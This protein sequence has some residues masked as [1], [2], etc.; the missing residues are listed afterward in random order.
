MLKSNKITYKVS[1]TALYFCSVFVIIYFLSPRSFQAFK[2]EYI[3]F[4]FCIIFFIFYLKSNFLYSKPL[5]FA[6]NNSVSNIAISIIVDSYYRFSVASNFDKDSS[7]FYM[8]APPNII[9]FTILC[10]FDVLF[11]ILIHIFFRLR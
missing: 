9:F 3:I 7:L 4:I 11:Y 8:L 2:E 6:F 10:F 1:M 5:I